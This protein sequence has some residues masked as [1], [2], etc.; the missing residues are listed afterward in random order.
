MQGKI[1]ITNDAPPKPRWNRAR[2]K[3]AA[4]RLRLCEQGRLKL[5]PGQIRDELFI[6]K[7]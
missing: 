7:S 5:T 3:L 2:R 4:K 1:I 6:V